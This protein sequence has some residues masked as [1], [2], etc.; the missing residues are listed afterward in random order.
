MWVQLFNNRLVTLPVINK[1]VNDTPAEMLPPLGVFL[2]PFTGFWQNAETEKPNI[3]S[4]VVLSQLKAP[5]TLS[6]IHI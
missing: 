6:L 2:N 1:I 5:A 3:K 4:K